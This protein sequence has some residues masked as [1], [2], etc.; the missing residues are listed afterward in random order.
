MSSTCSARVHWI[1]KPCA[2][3]YPHLSVHPLQLQ[4]D[5]ARAH[6]FSWGLAQVTSITVPPGLAQREE[7]E[8]GEGPA[9]GNCC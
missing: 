9:W 7:H 8:A 5:H 1:C 3:F 6:P 4:Q 2:T